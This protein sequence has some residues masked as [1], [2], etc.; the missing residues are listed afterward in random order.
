MTVLDILKPL[1]ARA[2]VV[3]THGLD[4]AT[5]L[6]LSSEFP[7]IIEAAKAAA[8]LFAK[9]VGRLVE[10]HHVVAHVHVAVPVDPVGLH[11]GAVTVE[12]GAKIEF[13][14]GVRS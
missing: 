6:R 8:E 13:D 4:D 3:R 7:E 1:R 10:G 9:R 11:G 14:H 12:R 5:L 2:G